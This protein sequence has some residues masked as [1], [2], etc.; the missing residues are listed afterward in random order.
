MASHATLVRNSLVQECLL[1]M[2]D[3]DYLGA[4]VC[5]RTRLPEQFLWA[6]LQ[7][8]EK[9]LKAIL[10]L[11]DGSAKGIG[12]KLA[13]AL[14]RVD[15]IADLNIHLPDDVRVFVG[16]LDRFGENRYL[17]RGY[18]M[19]GMELISLDESYWHIRRYCWNMRAYARAAKV[20]ETDFLRSYA[21]FYR[22]PRHLKSPWKHHLFSGYLEDVLKGKKGLEPY[23]AL[24]WQNMYFGKREKKTVSFHS[25]SWAASP[26]HFRHPQ[27]FT[28]LAKIIDFPKDVKQE[29]SP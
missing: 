26:A 3:R 6:A 21:K 20:D 11:H 9:T 12:H 8:I 18:Y 23:D 24:V 15:E 16:Y 29:L 1:D 22:D 13:R 4:R 25:L 27:V 10:I 14:K 28:E 17:E 19:R 5:W 7:A 2:A